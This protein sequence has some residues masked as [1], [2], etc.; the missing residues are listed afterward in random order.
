M[1]NETLK[2]LTSDLISLLQI[3]YEF[4]GYIFGRITVKSPIKKLILV[5]SRDNSK[6]PIDNSRGWIC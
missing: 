1:K 4:S 6:G 5:K 2:Y 3:M